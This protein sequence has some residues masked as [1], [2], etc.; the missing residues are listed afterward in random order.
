MEK[1]QEVVVVSVV[2]SFTL[3]QVSLSQYEQKLVIFLFVNCKRLVLL[4]SL[5]Q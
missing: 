2:L 4:P 5:K 3:K 1:V